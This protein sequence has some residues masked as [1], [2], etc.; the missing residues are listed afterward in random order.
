MHEILHQLQ[1][2]LPIIRENSEDVCHHYILLKLN[3]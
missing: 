3:V 1:S 2:M